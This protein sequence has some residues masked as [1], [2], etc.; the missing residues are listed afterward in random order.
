MLTLYSSLNAPPF[1]CL[2]LA[3][4]S[5]SSL[6]RSLL[7][8][9]FIPAFC[10]LLPHSSFESPSFTF[11]PLAL[12][13]LLCPRRQWRNPQAGRR[14]GG[15]GGES[16]PVTDRPVWRWPLGLC[17]SAKE[18]GGNPERWSSVRRGAVQASA[19]MFWNSGIQTGCSAGRRDTAAE[20]HLPKSVLGAEDMKF[21]SRSW[22]V[23]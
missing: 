18:N 5:S 4:S 13:S 21:G 12:S 15:G 20:P 19:F 3:P 6:Q 23:F 11:S 9:S 1:T 14:G 10:Y 16:R 8:F 17:P 22:S 7:F 2:Y